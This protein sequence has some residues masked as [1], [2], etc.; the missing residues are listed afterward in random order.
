MFLQ[1]EAIAVLCVL[2][3]TTRAA[4]RSVDR[5]IHLHLD[6]ERESKSYLDFFP[7]LA[8]ENMWQCSYITLGELKSIERIESECALFE[9]KLKIL[10]EGIERVKA[11]LVYFKELDCDPDE[12]IREV[13]ELAVKIMSEVY[14]FRSQKGVAISDRLRLTDAMT[15]SY[16][17]H[18]CSRLGWHTDPDK[19]Q[20][21]I[22]VL[23]KKPEAGGEFMVRERGSRTLKEDSLFVHRT[24]V[25]APKVSE[26]TRL[27]RQEEFS[28]TIWP[29]YINHAVKELTGGDRVLL[30][31][32]A[33]FLKKPAEGSSV[34]H[35]CTMPTR[36]D[37]CNTSRHLY[38]QQPPLLESNEE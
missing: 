27:I 16:Q 13:L 15:L 5:I 28:I 9:S 6:E 18:F 10:R 30:S 11:P 32:E 1:R 8:K 25:I 26:G 24:A 37:R 14:D 2:I 20:M 35:E 3:G 17:S 34:H 22:G 21:N 38:E 23:L 29:S 12:L 4:S 31:G 33:K 19:D 36:L 7:A